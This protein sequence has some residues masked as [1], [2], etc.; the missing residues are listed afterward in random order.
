MKSW[1]EGAWRK[2]RAPGVGA[3]AEERQQAEATIG[4]HRHPVG[5]VHPGLPG[6]GPP[7]RRVT[8]T[9]RRLPRPIWFAQDS[10]AALRS[11]SRSARWSA[12]DSLIDRGGGV[13]SASLRGPAHGLALGGQPE[14]LEPPV[15]RR[16]AALEQPARLEPVG[17]AGD[18]RGIAVEDAGQ[19]VDRSLLAGVERVSRWTC[20]GASSNSAAI[21]NTRALLTMAMSRMRIQASCAI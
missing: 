1:R 5:G 6:A 17:D 7:P 4:T 18:V 12:R 19:G 2:R 20:I 9:A 21:A 15:V 13:S 3:D 8:R 16:A 14:Q 11:R 10:P